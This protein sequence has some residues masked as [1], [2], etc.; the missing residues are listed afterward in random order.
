MSRRLSYLLVLTL[1]GC[2]GS[3]TSPPNGDV[4]LEV[5]VARVSGEPTVRAEVTNDQTE[6]IRHGVGCSFWDPGMQLF[7]LDALGTKLFL[8]DNRARPLC[9][10][11]IAVLQSGGRFNESARLEGILYTE[12][13]EPLPMQPGK[14]TAVVSFAWS[15]V[16]DPNAPWQTIEK[17]VAFHWPV[18]Q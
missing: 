11:G 4:T 18:L 7:F 16:E 15:S 1:L 9:P 12:A 13:G 5:V 14:Y 3:T 6:A 10:N 8:G 2:D 17:R